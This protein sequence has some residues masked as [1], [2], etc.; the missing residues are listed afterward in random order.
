MTT[1]AVKFKAIGIET[2]L[3]IGSR[4][5][6]FEDGIA[7]ASWPDALRIQTPDDETIFP[8]S[9]ESKHARVMV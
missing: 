4:V 2:L 9:T 7:P 8:P 1:E 3:H 6:G 5:P